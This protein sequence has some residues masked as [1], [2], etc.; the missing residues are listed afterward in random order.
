MTRIGVLGGTFDP[1]HTGH[2]AI[3]EAAREDREI[4]QCLRRV[5]M[6]SV[7][8]VDDAPGRVPGC[9][10]R[11]TGALVPQDD[12]LMAERLEGSHGVDER[13][14]LPDR[15]G[16]DVDRGDACAERRR[17]G[18]EGDARPCGRLVEEGGDADA[19]QGVAAASRR[20]ELLLRQFGRVERVEQNHL[21]LVVPQVL[22]PGEDVG[23]VVQQVA[24]Q[25]HDPAAPGAPGEFVL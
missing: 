16:S 4:E 19:A 21:V 1:I 13:L 20:V 11:C 6:P 25:E 2:L 10:P 22:K 3:A 15:R 9:D 23:H 8:G 17:R 18:L 5:G 24:E 14:P 12:D 7:A